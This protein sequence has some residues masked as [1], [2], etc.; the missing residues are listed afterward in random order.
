MPVF[1]QPQFVGRADRYLTVGADSESAVERY[2]FGSGEQAIAQIGLGGRAQDHGG[3]TGGQCAALG[4]VHM[5]SVNQI[6]AGVNV[7]LVQQM[8]DRGGAA[9]GQ[10][11]FD[12]RPLLGYVDMDGST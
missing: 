6:P 3:L 11:G 9:P 12:F 1:K 7:C 8:P 4:I 2:P 5:G 10:A